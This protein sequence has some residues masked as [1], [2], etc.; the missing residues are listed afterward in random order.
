MIGGC[1]FGPFLKRWTIIPKVSQLWW[2]QN[3]VQ[4]SFAWLL[5]WTIKG[6]FQGEMI[7]KPSFTTA[8]RELQL[9]KHVQ[10]HIV[11]NI[12]WDCRAKPVDYFL[13]E[14]PVYGITLQPGNQNI[15]ATACD[16]GKLRIFDMRSSTSPEIILASKRSPFHSIMFHPNEGRIVASAS[17]K[18]GPELWDVRNP[19][20]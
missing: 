1:C 3:M 6:Y 20:T 14:K 18:D 10:P 13:H 4:T 2:K 17:A 19:L 11:I 16:D 7:C 5:V 8:N 15:F 9:F 12:S